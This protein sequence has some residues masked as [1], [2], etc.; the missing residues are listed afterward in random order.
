[1]AANSMKSL[2]DLPPGGTPAER[3][4]AFQVVWAKL[5]GD[6]RPLL[7][8]EDPDRLRK[9]IVDLAAKRLHQLPS[10]L[11]GLLAAVQEG[12]VRLLESGVED[13]DHAVIRTRDFASTAFLVEGAGSPGDPA[14]PALAI[15]VLDSLPPNHW[16][17]KALPVD[18]C[19][20]SDGKPCLEIIRKP[21]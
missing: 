18:D 14:I 9:D 16:L 17:R 5:T 6:A 8:N 15:G 20:Q 1:A 2:R 7:P 19:Y 3:L 11:E 13:P 4:D 21:S 10:N 12:M